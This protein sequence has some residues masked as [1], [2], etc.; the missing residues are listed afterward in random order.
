MKKVGW[1]LSPC[2]ALKIRLL[3]YFF[4]LPQKHNKISNYQTTIHLFCGDQTICFRLLESLPWWGCFRGDG[5]WG[6]TLS[7]TVNEILSSC[8]WVMS[9][10]T[11]NVFFRLNHVVCWNVSI[12]SLHN[13]YILIAVDFAN[14]RNF[15]ESR[16][17]KAIPYDY[18]APPEMMNPESSRYS[19]AL[20]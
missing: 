11:W 8:H 14:F 4:P 9:S 7:L 18:A 12:I 1:T 6:W 3:N 13:K 17:K 15:W 10:Q 2:E 20:G 19:T 16:N 5:R